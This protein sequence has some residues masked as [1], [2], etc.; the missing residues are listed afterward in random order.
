[1]ID[2]CLLLQINSP[3][4]EKARWP[5]WMRT[6]SSLSVSKRN[7]SFLILPG[8]RHSGRVEGN[9][10]EKKKRFSVFYSLQKIC[11]YL[12][13]FFRFYIDFH[14]WNLKEQ[15]L[16]PFPKLCDEAFASSRT[17]GGFHTHWYLFILFIKLSACSRRQDQL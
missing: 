17:R 14:R 10:S 8:N 4:V 6:R 9:K 7:Q 16:F 5:P 1:M 2:Q 11:D 3:S 12:N 13:S 15:F